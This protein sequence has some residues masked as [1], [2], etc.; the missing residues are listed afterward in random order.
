MK[1]KCIMVMAVATALAVAAVYA[2]RKFGKIA[3]YHYGRATFV[4]GT[5]RSP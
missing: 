5:S 3:K 2:G 1:K 4:V